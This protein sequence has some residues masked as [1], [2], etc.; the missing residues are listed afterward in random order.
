[1]HH[2]HREFILRHIERGLPKR[3][4]R[5]AQRSLTDTATGYRMAVATAVSGGAA[6]L[7]MVVFEETDSEIVAVS[8]HPLEERDVE[9]KSETEGGQHDR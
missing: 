7:R 9:R 4:I 5:E 6:H 2:L 3:I 8:I 1:M